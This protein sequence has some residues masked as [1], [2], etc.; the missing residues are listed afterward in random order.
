M[1][2]HHFLLTHLET[3]AL[4]GQALVCAEARYAS[5]RWKGAERLDRRFVPAPAWKAIEVEV[6]DGWSKGL[7]AVESAVFATVVPEGHRGSLRAKFLTGFP[8]DAVPMAAAQTLD[9]YLNA[10]RF[11]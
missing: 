4:V 5:V 1:T 11:V 3:G 8:V 6:R 2:A 7:V 9:Q 10:Q